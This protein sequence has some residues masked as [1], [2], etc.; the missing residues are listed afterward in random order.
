MLLLAVS[1]IFLNAEVAFALDRGSFKFGEV[2]LGEG[3]KARIKI[4]KGSGRITAYES[5]GAVVLSLRDGTEYGFDVGQIRVCDRKTKKLYAVYSDDIERTP[6][7]SMRGIEARYG[8]IEYIGGG[9]VR[10]EVFWKEKLDGY[11]SVDLDAIQFTYLEIK[12]SKH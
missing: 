1:L 3:D 4:E 8:K 7:E 11:G 12:P 10:F 5:G 2:S 6:G 9:K